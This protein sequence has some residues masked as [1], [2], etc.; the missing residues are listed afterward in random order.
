TSARDPAHPLADFQVGIGVA[1]GPAVAGKIGTAD[2]AKVGVF[3]PVVNLASRLQGM[4]RILRAPILMDETTAAVACERLPRELGRCRRLLKVKPYGMEN[5]VVVSELLPPASSFP[6]LTDEQI[7]HYEAALDAFRDGQWNRAS[8][9]LHQV[10]P[11]DRGKDFLT[12]LIIQHD[13]T[14]PA[15]WDG[16]VPLQAKNG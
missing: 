3:G 13:H 14:P 7:A 4:T 8:G 9:L 2:Q 1:T 12:S 11:Q 5:A 15:N 6:V 10:P 16:S